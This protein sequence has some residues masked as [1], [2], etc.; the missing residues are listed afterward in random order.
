MSKLKNTQTKLDWINNNPRI[1][2]S[3]SYHLNNG[4]E[5]PQMV[6][7]YSPVAAEEAA[8]FISTKMLPSDINSIVYKEKGLLSREVNFIRQ[9]LDRVSKINFYDVAETSGDSSLPF[10][11]EL[12]EA[13]LLYKYIPVTPNKEVNDLAIEKVGDFVTQAMLGKIKYDSILADSEVVDF[14]TQVID[15]SKEMQ[16]DNFLNLFVLSG[17]RLGNSHNPERMLQN[18]YSSMNEGDY[19]AVVQG[20]YRQGIEDLIVSDY[21]SIVD[22]EGNLMMQKI[23]AEELNPGGEHHVFWEDSINPGVRFGTKVQKNENGLGKDLAD[24]QYVNLFKSNRFKETE[25]R[26]MILKT[27][28]SFVDIAYDKNMDHGLFF[29]EK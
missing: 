15:I 5:I 14:K 27:G 21:Q 11:Y 18:I 28:F 2:K 12:I 20:L 13:D 25:L 26:E 23:I 10:I 8:N 22:Q 16:I 9:R 1:K 4:S 7:G 19:L 17:S 29:L 3:I 24:G 6:F